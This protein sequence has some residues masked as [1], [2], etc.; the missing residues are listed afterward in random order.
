MQEYALPLEIRLI[1]QEHLLGTPHYIDLVMR[2]SKSLVQH[3]RQAYIGIVWYILWR[4][5][6]REWF[7]LEQDL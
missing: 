1:L 7:S 2:V 5:Q 6:T 3:C 4:W